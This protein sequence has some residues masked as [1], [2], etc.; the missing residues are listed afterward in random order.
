MSDWVPT[1]SPPSW[2]LTV[3]AVQLHPMTSD[4]YRWHSK[5]KVTNLLLNAIVSPSSP[6]P[7]LSGWPFGC[8]VGLREKKGGLI[9]NADTRSLLGVSRQ[10]GI[11]FACDGYHS[12][13]KPQALRYSSWLERGDSSEC[14]EEMNPADDNLF[15]TLDMSDK[16]V[17]SKRFIPT[18]SITQINNVGDQKFEVVTGN[19]TFV[20]RAES[21]FDRNEWVSVLQQT[22]KDQKS[23]SS[24]SIFQSSSTASEEKQGYLE[25]RGLRSKLYVVVSGDKV[26]LYKNMEV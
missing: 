2:S 9:P 1:V 7:L 15:D 17:Y 5:V 16:E 11:L 22:I 3:A 4:M 8:V 24:E 13:R 25:L 21:D 19:R 18:A 14:N 12:N 6:S 10:A 20:F 26:F 23:S